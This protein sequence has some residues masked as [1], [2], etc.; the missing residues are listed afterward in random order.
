MEVIHGKSLEQFIPLLKSYPYDRKNFRFIGSPIDGIQFNDNEIVFV[1]FKTGRS[2]LTKK[3]RR[4][5][6]L[7]KKKKVKFSELK[8]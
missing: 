1:E 7:I 2:S 4:I 8:A 6:D 3:Q 5:K